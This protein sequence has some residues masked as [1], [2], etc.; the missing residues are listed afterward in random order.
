MGK[1]AATRDSILEF[2]RGEVARSG[3]RAVSIGSL[4]SGLGLSKSG[5]FAHFSS[6]EALEAA[7]IDHAAERFTAEVIRPAL[8]VQ[9]GEPRV[10][11]LLEGW[12]RW[13]RDENQGRGCVFVAAAPEL[14]DRPGLARDRLVSQ[15]QE[16]LEF[17][18]SMVR[19][20]VNEGHFRAD[21]DPLQFAF[22]AH[23]ILLGLHHAVRLLEDPRG[24][25]RAHTAID[26]LIAAA[27]PQ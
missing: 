2:A 9:R 8:K 13:F 23:G 17:L 11:A 18:A 10:R 20:A 21:I 12:I 3:F 19:T 14:D 16:W 4:A 26:R 15:Q 24:L 22:E 27:Q 5:V 6:K 7:I 25:E 1:G